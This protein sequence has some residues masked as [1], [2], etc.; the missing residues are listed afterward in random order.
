M[1]IVDKNNKVSIGEIK[2]MSENMFGDLVKAV[3]DI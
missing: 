3:V 1:K 2:S